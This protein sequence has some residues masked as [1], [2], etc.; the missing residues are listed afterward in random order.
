MH[1]LRGAIQSNMENTINGKYMEIQYGKSY[2]NH[3]NCISSTL[4]CLFTFLFYLNFLR[5]FENITD[6]FAYSIQAAFPSERLGMGAFRIAL[7]SVFNR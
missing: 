1:L 5:K 3:I 7:E 6:Q 4:I 2:Q